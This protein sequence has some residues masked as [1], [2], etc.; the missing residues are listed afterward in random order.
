MSRSNSPTPPPAMQVQVVSRRS[1]LAAGA[2]AT[3]LSS[4]L[5]LQVAQAGGETAA[6]A[7]SAE[8]GSG[9]TPLQGRIPVSP[10]MTHSKQFEEALQSILADAE[11]IAGEPLTIELPEL[12]ENGNVV[13]FTVA[14]DNPMTDADYVRTLYLLSTANP[15]ALVATFH[16]F[17][18]TGKA[19][20]SGRMRLAKTQ[21]VVTI[22]ELSTGQVLVAVRQ[23]EVTIGGCGNE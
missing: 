1:F 21:D 18:A 19:S 12:A 20:V 8:Q 3:A 23:I 17:P 13:P 7:S 6:P 14:V 2:A 22:A 15:Q 4:L 9:S 11:P 10:G 5:A 16:L